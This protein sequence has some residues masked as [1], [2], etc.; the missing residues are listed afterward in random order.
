MN[1][2]TKIWSETKGTLR[3]EELGFFYQRFEKKNPQ[4]TKKRNSL[5]PVR[6]D[7]TDMWIPGDNLRFLKPLFPTAC[8]FREHRFRFRF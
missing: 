1:G 7:D 4:Q 8:G 3:G 2:K 5:N 6:E